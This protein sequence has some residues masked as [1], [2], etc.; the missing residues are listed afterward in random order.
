MGG[1]HSK[2]YGCQL[3]YLVC[4]VCDVTIRRHIHVSKPTFSQNLT[5]HSYSYTRNPLN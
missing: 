4:G 1:V 3:L 2:A 5:Q